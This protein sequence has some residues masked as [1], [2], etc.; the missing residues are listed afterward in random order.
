MGLNSVTGELFAVKEIEVRASLN[1][2]DTRQL[3]KLG[4]EIELM[5]NLNH[6]HIVRYVAFVGFIVL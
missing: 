1:T 4:E 5:H 6:K 2:D 3:Q